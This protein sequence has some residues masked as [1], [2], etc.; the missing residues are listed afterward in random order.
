MGGATVDGSYGEPVDVGSWNPTISRVLAPSQ[1]VVWDF[2]R[3]QQYGW[4]NGKMN[5]TTY[6]IHFGVKMN[7]LGVFFSFF[8][9]HVSFKAYPGTPKNDAILFWLGIPRDPFDQTTKVSVGEIR[10]NGFGFHFSNEKNSLFKVYRPRW[11]GWFQ[12]VF[13]STPK[14]WGRFP[15]W[16]IF[17]NWVGSTTN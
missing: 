4:N 6:S 11:Q 16:L 12:I 13:I 14:P 2:L 9:G 1:V 5:L 17:F 8:F 10:F 3:C 15:C 7:K